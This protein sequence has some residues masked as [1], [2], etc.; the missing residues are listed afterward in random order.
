MRIFISGEDERFRCLR[1]ELGEHE[2][3]SD[4]VEAQI[5][6]TKWPTQCDVHNGAALVTCGPGNGPDGSTDLLLDEEYQRDIAWMTAEGALSAAMN[7]GGTAICGAECMVVG[8]GRI[9][10]AL[11]ERLAALGGRVTVLSRRREAFEEISSCGAKAALTADACKE[12]QGKKYIFSTPP[13]MTLDERVLSMADDDVLMID[14]ASP[15]YGVDM[16]TARRLGLRAWREPGLPGRYCP[17]NAARAIYDAL[18]RHGIL[19]GGR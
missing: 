9:G 19:E 5:T 8:W 16:D 18:L 1:D 6:I 7:A 17:V 10:R 11:T 2:L 13:V 12:V 3:V 4:A 15:P 14:L